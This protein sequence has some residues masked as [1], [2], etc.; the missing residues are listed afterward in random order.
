MMGCG[1]SMRVWSRLCCASGPRV[2]KKMLH[3][4]KG[5]EWTHIVSV[6]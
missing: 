1:S 6:R 4:A 2:I 5:E 3:M